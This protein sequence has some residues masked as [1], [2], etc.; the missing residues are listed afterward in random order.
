MENINEP[1][2]VIEANKKKW[3]SYHLAVCYVWIALLILFPLWLLH[4]DSWT[5][6]SKIYVFGFGSVLFSAIASVTYLLRRLGI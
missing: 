4:E 5:T 3:T 6:S 2:K 1:R